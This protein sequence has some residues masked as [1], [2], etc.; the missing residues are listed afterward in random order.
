MEKEKFEY[1]FNNGLQFKVVLGEDGYNVNL[2]GGTLQQPLM[3]TFTSFEEM[4]YALAPIVQENVQD[5]FEFGIFSSDL[6]CNFAENTSLEC[7]EAAEILL[8]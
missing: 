4:L 3:G 8:K 7:Y 1:P 2:S 6:W 5:R